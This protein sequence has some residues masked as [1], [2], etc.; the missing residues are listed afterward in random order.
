MECLTELENC[1]ALRGICQ[2]GVVDVAS[3]QRSSRSES[4]AP[5]D[6]VVFEVQHGRPRSRV[7]A[8][9]LFDE[10]QHSRLEGRL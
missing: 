8:Q 1:G 9:D 3:V 2:L 10:Q 6:T 5:I 7:L 4:E